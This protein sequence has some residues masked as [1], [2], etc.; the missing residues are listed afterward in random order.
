MKNKTGK[1]KKEIVKKKSIYLFFILLNLQ[2]FIFNPIAHADQSVSATVLPPPSDFQFAL[3]SPSEQPLQ[4]NETTSYQ[5]TYGV[6]Q[7]A[8]IPTT[9]TIVANWSSATA[10]NGAQLLDYVTSSAS[11]GYNGAVPVVNP[12]NKTITWT[13]PNFPAGITN[14]TVTFKLYTLN[15][16]T[17]STPFT[18]HVSMNNQYI[19]LPEQ[20][21]TQ[22]YQYNTPPSVSTNATPTP[23]TQT[24]AQSTTPTPTI[25]PSLQF[26]NVNV[27]GI[28]D[29]NATIQTTTDTPAAFTINYGTSP[30]DFAKTIETNTYAYQKT[31]TLSGLAPDTTYYFKITR[32]DASGETITS[33]IF[34]FHTAKNS[35]VPNIQDNLIVLSSEGNVLNSNA[36]NES[37][38]KNPSVILTAN[39]NYNIAYTL[40]RPISLKSIDVIVQNNVLGASSVA[41]INDPGEIVIPMEQKSQT[42]YVANLQNLPPGSYDINI[43][44]ID[45]QGNILEKKIS[46]LKVM[47]PLTVYAADTD[48]PL[49]DARIYLLYY[50][51]QQKNYEPIKSTF[52]GNITNPSYT[53]F[54]GQSNI[55]LPAGQYRIEESALFYKKA[56]VDFTI[57]NGISQDFP[58]IYLKR[59]FSPLSF[60]SFTKDY[61]GDSWDKVVST[62]HTLSTSIRIFH[63]ISVTILSS[64]VIISFLFFLFR[65]HIHFKHLPIFL[66]FHI[67]WLLNRHQKRY[68]YGSI[69][70]EDNSSLSRVLIEVED[71]DK[72]TI[73]A[74][75]L[76][77][78]SGKF[79]FKNSFP[80]SI[81]LLITKEGFVPALISLE[82]EQE[83]PKNGIKVILAKSISHNKSPFIFLM[84]IAEKIAGLLFEVS[85]VFS[86]ILEVLF[87]SLYGFEKIAIYFIL[88]FANIILW[89]FY[90]RD[91]TL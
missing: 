7:A 56:V 65:S 76:S 32:T 26:T 49:S 63:L 88:S 34:T 72:K 50:D 80:N 67:D 45:T 68:I 47:P 9:I 75:I 2:F 69:T 35:P 64:L 19:T 60:L 87:L 36:Q 37:D 23:P 42:L 33:D 39:S 84:E 21:I 17:H 18:I 48:S 91:K 70:N 6:L 66:L 90:L 1:I 82:R 27:T 8:T 61:L 24:I 53:N 51:I 38:K 85:L 11:T 22:T 73:L 79:Y 86:I 29:D 41:P 46:A 78:K 10:P 74:E 25:P 58:V 52:F 15:S 3:S 55:T 89:L 59:D 54:N 31:L 30:S 83:V 20:S 13:I 44:I 40:V 81:N 14:Q 12:I 5:I 16:Y 28:S 77:N 62:L 43:R 4:Q 71:S 57:G